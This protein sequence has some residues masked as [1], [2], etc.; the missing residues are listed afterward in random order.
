MSYY[1][2]LDD[3]RNPSDVTWCIHFPKDRASWVVVRNYKQFC[4]HITEHG[5]PEF[6]S[7]DHDLAEEHYH[8]PTDELKKFDY[9]E[10]TG[11]DCAKW[12]CDF[13]QKNKC[14]VPNYTVHSMN[15]VGAK[16][17][18]TYIKNFKSFLNL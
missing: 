14:R 10:K 1:L 8:D 18:D 15:P 16:N 17:I 7:F 4:N 2:F 9:K 5:L 13:C 11:Y 3:L 12:L 6:I